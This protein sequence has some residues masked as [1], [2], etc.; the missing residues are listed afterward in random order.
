MEDQGTKD[1]TVTG[2]KADR[3][4]NST[5]G[6]LLETEVCS[7]FGFIEPALKCR[8]LLPNHQNDAPYPCLNQVGIRLGVCQTRPSFV[9]ESDNIP[10][11]LTSLQVF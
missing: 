3:K 2:S 6:P 1:A 4:K 5:E 10:T 9:R 11:D 7:D 8:S